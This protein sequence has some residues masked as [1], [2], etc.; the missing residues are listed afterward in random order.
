MIM[1]VK[2]A[3]LYVSPHTFLELCKGLY[4]TRNVRIIANAVPEDAK[5]IRAFTTDDV[6][7]WGKIGLVI[8]SESFEEIKEGNLMP[9]LSNPIFEK[10]R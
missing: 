10:V 9:T 6:T 1:S 4:E 2:H 8:E 3:I 7:G 5:F